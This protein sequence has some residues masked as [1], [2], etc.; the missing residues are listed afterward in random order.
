MNNFTAVHRILLW[1]VFIRV[2]ISFRLTSKST[3]P[4]QRGRTSITGLGLELGKIM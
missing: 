1:L 3:H 4:Y 2:T